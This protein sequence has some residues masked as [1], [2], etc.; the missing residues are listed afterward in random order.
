MSMHFLRIIILLTASFASAYGEETAA[1]KYGFRKF[2]DE[3]FLPPA[4]YRLKF[5]RAKR[6]KDHGSMGFFSFRHAFDK[7]IQMW[8]FGFEKDG[9]FRVRFERFSK[10]QDHKWQEVLVGYCGTGAE[11]YAIEPNHDYIMRVPLWPYLFS[12][13]RGVVLLSGQ[14]HI[15]IS[16]EFDADIVRKNADKTQWRNKSSSTSK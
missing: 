14:R 11:T 7:P 4:T 3:T 6:D 9:S 12:G 10:L 2:P 13:F 5:L 16:D 8:G 1:K 15:V